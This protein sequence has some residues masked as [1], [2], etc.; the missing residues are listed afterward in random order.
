MVYICCIVNFQ[1][2]SESHSKS[3]SDSHPDS[4]SSEE[5]FRTAPTVNGATDQSVITEEFARGDSLRR[6]RA[7]KEV[8]V[9]YKKT[10]GILSII[11]AHI[12]P[13]YNLS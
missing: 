12:G 4:S 8:K 11:V 7:L 10:I 9:F 3:L 13:N 6:R 1:D 2:S 5:H